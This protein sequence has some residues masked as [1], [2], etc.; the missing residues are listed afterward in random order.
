MCLLY[1]HTINLGPHPKRSNS[2]KLH[3]YYIDITSTP[4][5]STKPKAPSPGAE[6]ESTTPS[7]NIHHLMARALRCTSLKTKLDP[8]A[9]FLN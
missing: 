6:F 9:R 4:P 2:Y 8:L 1:L 3:M 7:P 5:S